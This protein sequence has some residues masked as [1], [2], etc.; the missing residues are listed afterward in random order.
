MFPVNVLSDTST[1]VAAM[2]PPAASDMK[3]PASPF[4]NVRPRNVTCRPPSIPRVAP[5]PLNSCTPLPPL[6]P[7][8][9]VFAWPDPTK[10]RST[11]TV[12]VAVRLYVPGQMTIVSPAL[13]ASTA[14][15]IVL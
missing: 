8:M 2:A 3:A 6:A 7:S 9:M 4:R 11:G 13:A 14:A 5:S 1:V 10:V 12:T 15:W